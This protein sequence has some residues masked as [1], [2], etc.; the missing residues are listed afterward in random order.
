MLGLIVTTTSLRS[1][2][3]TEESSLIDTSQFKNGMSIIWDGGI[4]IIVEFQHVKPG[5][6]P[7]FVRTVL[8]NVRTGATIER[9]FRAGEKMEQAILDRRKMQ[10]LYNTGDDYYFMD[11]EDFEQISLPA[12]SIG[13][14]IKY[15]K[16]NIEV[17]VL[18]HASDIIGVEIPFFVELEVTQTDP[19]VRGDTVSG[20]GKPATLETGA[21]V[22]VPFFVN[23][24][25]RI[26]VDTRTD[27]YIERV[28]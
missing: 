19:G 6:G 21:V 26:K 10:Y 13:D 20:S 2:R 7:A 22:Q 17:T 23:V 9:K 16:E 27:T 18:M 28:K 24:G 14:G 15:L 5:K 4:Y 8:K 1:Q 3:V 25:D 11:M 12:E